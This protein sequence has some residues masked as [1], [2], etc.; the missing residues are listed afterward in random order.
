MSGKIIAGQASKSGWAAKTKG[1]RSG[2]DYLPTQFEV[3]WGSHSWRI[4][5]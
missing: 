5:C 1:W 3:L 4:M 2:E